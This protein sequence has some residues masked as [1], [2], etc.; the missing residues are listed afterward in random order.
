MKVNFFNIYLDN[1]DQKEALDM[2]R[3][4]FRSSRAHAIFF[5][6]AHCFNIAQKNPAYF[7]AINNADLL[8]NDGIGI[9]FGS[10]VAGIKLKQNMNG[11]DLIPQILGLS[12]IEQ[13]PVYFLGG[14]PGVAQAAAEKAAANIPG[15]KIAGYHSGYFSIEQQPDLIQQINQSGARVLVL[16]MGVPKQ[17]LWAEKHLQSFENLKI[18]IAGGAIL[19]FLS[20]N[21]SRAPLWLRKMNMEWVYRFYLEPSRL[22]YRYTTGI[23]QYFYYLAVKR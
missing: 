6:N 16:G 13:Q 14:R 20:E 17:E 2:C 15:L 1:I 10:V 3:T 5:L 12:A 18:V 21:V 7:S 23:L 19:D 9:K 4:Y 22:F 11:T 8:L